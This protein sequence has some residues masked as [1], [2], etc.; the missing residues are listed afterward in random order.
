MKQL[1]LGLGAVDAESTS[2][3]CLGSS[4]CRFNVLAGA[5]AGAVFQRV[6]AVLFCKEKLCLER[7]AGSD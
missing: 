2:S 3:R 6:T 4:G 7:C 5:L 1:C